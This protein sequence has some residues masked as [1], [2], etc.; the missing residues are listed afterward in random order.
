MLR[1]HSLV[2]LVLGSFYHLPSPINISYWWNWGSIVGVVLVLQIFTG[3]FLTMHYV[4]DVGKA[5]DSVVH[6]HRDVHYG[7]LIRSMHAN[8]A[9]L[10]LFGIFMHVGRGLYY[11][12]YLKFHVW[13]VGV[14]M[15]IVGMLTAFLGYVLP[16]GQMSFWGATV[17][18]NLVSAVP[19]I[20][21]DIVY[22]LWGGFSVGG[23]TLT[24]FYTFH[25]L[26]PF[27]LVVLSLVHLVFL[28]TGGSTNPLKGSSNS[29]KI[30]FWP[31]SGVKD[32]VGFFLL[33]VAYM[34]IVLLNSNV[35][36]DPENFMK[37]NSL[38]TPTHIKPEWYFLYA[39]AI[40]RCIPNKGLGVLGL[41]MSILTLFLLP[42]LAVVFNKLSGK[43]FFFQVVFW[44]WSVNFLL[45]TWL[46]G[47]PVEDPYIVMA[48]VCSVVYFVSLLLLS[49]V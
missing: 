5:F 36:M 47:A 2:D 21:S 27:L 14:L 35:F 18:T 6:I 42:V 7:W 29:L 33:G 3:L 30:Y 15:L 13:G 38:V 1:K 31:Y 34:F 22:W 9:S 44:V 39:Y 24:R 48:Q 41:V 37:A 40:L 45:L 32:V 10:F 11:K 46:G 26:F 16:W 25:F 12:S 20:G 49:V 43:S 17:I 8:G 19:Y 4:G 23:A 28:H